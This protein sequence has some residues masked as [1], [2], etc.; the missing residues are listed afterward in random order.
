MEK[1]RIR[2]GMFLDGAEWSEAAA[3]LGEVRLGPAGLLDFLETRLGLAAPKVHPAFRINA[4]KERLSAVDAQSKQQSWFSRSFAQDAWST[5]KQMLVWRDELVLGG[6]QG[7]PIKSGS[8]RLTALSDLEQLELPLPP[9]REDRLAFVLGQLTGK[10]KAAGNLN[11]SEI[12]LM[13][14][15]SLLPALWQ[16]VFKAL[17]GMGSAVKT[18]APPANKAMPE[19]KMIVGADEWESAEAL[20]LYLVADKENNNDTAIITGSDTHILDQALRRQGLPTLGQSEASRWRASLQIL[21]LVIANA[22]LPS[23]F[24]R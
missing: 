17:A 21:P 4:Y 12:T 19:I 18:D 24:P 20:A 22:W 3:S 11:V 2:F 23:I 15:S 8:A 5:A 9:G 7:Q 6:W 10:V 13:D 14:P 1:T 16:N